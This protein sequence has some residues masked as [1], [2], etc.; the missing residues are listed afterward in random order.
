MRLLEWWLGT[1]EVVLQW[2]TILQGK[3]LEVERQ[4][5]E[6][7]MILEGKSLEVEQQR[8]ELKTILEG[9]LQEGE[10]RLRM[11]MLSLGRM[12]VAQDR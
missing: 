10:Q 2:K 12:A 3:S 9:K 4:R 1:R 7:K 8:L 11:L 6:T 5:P